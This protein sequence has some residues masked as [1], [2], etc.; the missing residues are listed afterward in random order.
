MVAYTYTTT[1]LW[2]KHLDVYFKQVTYQ[3]SGIS[4][5][6]VF[7]GVSVQALAL[8]DM[9]NQ[10]SSELRTDT[11]RIE[12]PKTLRSYRLTY[13]KLWRSPVRKT[14]CNATRAMYV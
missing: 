6:Q 8:S 1:R 2:G 12:W 14:V 10:V 4:T 13:S 7:G 3:V 5:W 9:S 11:A